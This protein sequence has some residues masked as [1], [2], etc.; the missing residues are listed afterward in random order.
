MKLLSSL[1]KE[2]ILA[3]RGYYFYVEI[4]MTLLILVFFLFIIP[5]NF[6]KHVDEYIYLDL[7]KEI[8][9]AYLNQLL[10]Y[11]VDQK[12]EKVVIK[13]E[14]EKKKV[15]LYQTDHSNI[16]IMNSYEDMK[17]MGEKKSKPAAKIYLD[18]ENQLAYEHFL[19]GYESGRFKNIIKV[20]HM[21]SSETLEENMDALV[22]KPQFEDM[23]L[24]SDKENILPPVLVFNGSLMGMF[25]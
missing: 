20:I 16:H 19:Q 2:M 3:S 6:N 8:K 11:D 1:K 4:F 14:K 25:L 18:E 23:K 13:I 5:E 9:E 17:Y 24:L 10:Q 12:V 15:D 21:E 22:V 7:P